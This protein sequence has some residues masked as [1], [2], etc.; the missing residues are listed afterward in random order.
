MKKTLWII[1]LILLCLCIG[2]SESMNNTKYKLTLRLDGGTITS[3]RVMIFDEVTE[4]ELPTPTKEGYSFKGWM[5]NDELLTS[6]KITV[7]SK[8]TLKA[9][10]IKTD[11]K[12]TL[13]DEL[14]NTNTTMD[15]SYKK[16]FILPVLS[17]NGYEFVGWMYKDKL[18]NNNIYDYEE[19]ITL[20][21][22]WR[23][24]T[25]IVD[26]MDGNKEV[27]DSLKVKYLENIILPKLEKKGFNFLGWY[28]GE[29]KIE[30]GSYNLNYNVTL[31][32]KWE[33]KTYYISF[34]TNSSE[35]LDPIEV[36]YNTK[37]TLPS[38]SKKGSTF[39]GW[40]NGDTL[41]EDGRYDYFENLVLEAKWSEG[42]TKKLIDS[43]VVKLYNKQ[44]SSYD[45]ISLYK[46]GLFIDSS[47]YWKKYGIVLNDGNYV[48]SKILNSGDSIS[49]LGEY[50]YVLLAYTNYE[51][52][53]KFVSLDANVGDIVE[54]SSSLDSL[55]DG[56]INLTVSFY[57]TI[58]PEPSKEEFINYFDTLY[59]DIKEVNDN[60]E[61]VTNYMGHFI[62]WKTSNKEVITSDGIYNKTVITRNV[63]LTAYVNKKEIYEFSVKVKGTKDESEALTTGYFYTNFSSATLETFTNLD[64]AYISFLYVS[65]EAEFQSI[66]D[67]TTFLKNVVAKLV[68][69]AKKTNT[70][71]VISINQQNKEFGTIAKS[72]A[73]RK[74]FSENIV[75]LLNEYGFDGIDID[76]ETPTSSEATYFTLLMQDIY[77]AVKKNNPNHLVTAA[78]GGGK[79]QPPKYDL[80]NSSQYLDYINLMTYSMT[81]SN[82]QFHNALFKSSKGYTLSSCTIE[83]SIAIY[84]SYGVDRN[85]I[86]VGLAFYGIKQL[87]SEGV[88]TKSSSSMS[89]SY[90]SIYETYLINEDP[91]IDICFD[92]E[93]A[94]PY[95]Y[96]SL[97]KVFISYENELS[98]A[99]KCD[100]VNT[101]G[102]AG[103]MYWQDGQDHED[104]LL[105]YIKQYINK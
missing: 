20:K 74:K 53:S 3:E 4:V 89:I 84:D 19:D 2:C 42:I 24:E 103:V 29:Q 70:K 21:A 25:Y 26:F 18:L 92:E 35:K 91:N 28:D 8:I 93:S 52:Y 1:P 40:Y 30:S 66:Y 64:I 32:A 99:K 37:Y 73:L 87:S 78:I 31:Y 69:L 65:S 82:G 81:S 104:D 39:L 96:D 11:Y 58:Y 94:S 63:T 6:S 51:Y 79:W 60:I 102:L 62:T 16:L 22:Y 95:I 47:K 10:W 105:N 85:K 13:I 50:D 72:E 71:M 46:K 48:I 7:D 12:I 83:E 88:G 90:R 101:L 27:A 57:K 34:N 54:F 76:W 59:K 23:E 67:N 5:Y 17:K 61:L 75:T 45:E 56:E 36:K 14:N 77:Q 98:I 41:V 38:I 33:P 44:T 68:P 55:K 80:A 43:F 100:Y 97:N 49:E 15:V 9:E 86:I